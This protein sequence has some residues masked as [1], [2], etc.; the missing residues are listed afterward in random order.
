M[1][2][3]SSARVA[4]K[5]DKLD[6]TS[7]SAHSILELTMTPA[8]VKSVDMVSSRLAI[9]SAFLTRSYQTE[10]MQ[11]QAIEVGT[12]YPVQQSYRSSQQ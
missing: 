2:E 4:E 5:K 12:Q 9:L 3:K 7:P 6:G 10:E 11:Q 8:Q 1:D